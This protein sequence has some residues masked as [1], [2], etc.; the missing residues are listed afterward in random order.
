MGSNVGLILPAIQ[1]NKSAVEEL[2]AWH[3]ATGSVACT[4][5]LFKYTSKGEGNTGVSSKSWYGCDWSQ[6]QV[7]C[8]AGGHITPLF[9]VGQKLPGW[10]GMGSRGRSVHSAPFR[11][12]EEQLSHLVLCQEAFLCRS[13]QPHQP[14]WLARSSFCISRGSCEAQG[15]P[16]MFVSH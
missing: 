11:S 10:G 2:A 9:Y 13:S 5:T 8:L 3:S 12:V 15:H 4:S 16:S 1:A 6:S 14:C 7:H